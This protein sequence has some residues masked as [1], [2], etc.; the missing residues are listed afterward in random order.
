[1]FSIYSTCLG[2]F[3]DRRLNDI[4][5]TRHR[6]PGCLRAVVGALVVVC[7]LLLLYRTV[8][9]PARDPTKEALCLLKKQTQFFDSGGKSYTGGAYYTTLL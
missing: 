8:L 1:M 3:R 4:F 9:K 5:I 2:L 6:P 7:V